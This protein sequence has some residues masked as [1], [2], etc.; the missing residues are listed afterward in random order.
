MWIVTAAGRLESLTKTT[1][2][3]LR[4]WS[5]PLKD[6][7]VESFSSK[8]FRFNLGSAVRRHFLFYVS[9]IASNNDFLMMKL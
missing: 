2:I 8:A 3:V 1:T 6:F 5:I 4:T 9:I 7:Q